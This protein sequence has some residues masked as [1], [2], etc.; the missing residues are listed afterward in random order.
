MLKLLFPLP[1]AITVAT[2]GGVDSMAILDFFKRGHDVTVA[3]YHHGTENSQRAM[4]FVANYCYDNKLPFVFGALN[5][6]KPK[7]LSMEEYWRN[8][9]YDF[10][11]NFD[12]VVTGHHLDDSVETYLWSAMHGKPKVPGLVRGNV[13]RPFLTTKKS[14]FIGWCKRHDVPWVED[15]SNTDTKYT[16]NYIRHELMP[17]ALKVNP[18][19]YTTVKKIILN[20]L[21]DLS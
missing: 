10:L 7:E 1:K 3:F 9:R 5:D 12:Y 21:S 14:E 13:H 19:L 20:K 18:G 11:K 6:N 16:R 17:H 4:E 2:S 8:H 15:K